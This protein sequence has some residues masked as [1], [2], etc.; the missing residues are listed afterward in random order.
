LPSESKILKSLRLELAYFS[1]LPWL[2]GRGAG[3]AGVILR[4]ERVR[5][6]RSDP[7]QP[8]KASEITPKFLD[9]TIRALKRW[10]YDFVTL[11][12]VCR[13]A[14]RMAEPRRFVCLTFDGAYKDLIGSAYP[15]LAKHGV[16]FAVYVPTAFPDG[17]GEAWW[18]ALEQVIAR[19]SRISLVMD[20]KELRFGISTTSEKYQLYALLEGWMRSLAPS[21]LSFAIRDICTRYSVDL[22]AVSREASLD[23]DDL[24]RLAADPLVTIGSAT[25][26]Y[27]VLSNLRE[28]DALR[29]MTMGR[30][31]AQA[32]FRRDI[33]HFAFP[34][35][36]RGT[37]RRQHV[38]MVEEAG[39]ASAV[40]TISGVVQTAGGSNLH[41]LPRIAWDGRLRSLRAMRVILSGAAFPPVKRVPSTKIQ[42]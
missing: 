34:F 29:E 5:P 20:R 15:V 8:L 27:P 22:I 18:L 12:E 32:A 28:A 21:D 39:F 33:R 3:G 35:G 14:V 11:D 36:D 16:P 26:N 1:G 23:W 4:F 25:V 13:R 38:A 24:G 17:L 30:A 42:D 37:F 19:E 41:A 9:R 40:S 6:R 2:R 31:V 10:K 7:F